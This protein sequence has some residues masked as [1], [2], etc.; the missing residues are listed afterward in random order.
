MCF[1][2][3]TKKSCMVA[4]PRESNYATPGMNHATVDETV[5]QPSGLFPLTIRVMCDSQGNQ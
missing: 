1:M 5:F 2:L 4:P 3:N